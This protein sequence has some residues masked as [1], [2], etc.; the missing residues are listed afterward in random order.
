VGSICGLL[1][2]KFTVYAGLGLINSINNSVKGSTIINVIT[3]Q[4]IRAGSKQVTVQAND[5]VRQA[6]RIFTS[7]YKFLMLA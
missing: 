1:N 6:T 4:R 5:R 2:S 3:G 7:V